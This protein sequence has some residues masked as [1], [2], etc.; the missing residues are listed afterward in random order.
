[1]KVKATLAVFLCAIG[2]PV[3]ARGQNLIT[4]G[5]FETGNFSGWTVSGNPQY[6]LVAGFSYGYFHPESGND[7]AMLGSIGSESFLSQTISTNPGSYYSVSFDLASDG[8]TTNQL[9]VLA[10][11]DTLL[12]VTD[13]PKSNYTV[14]TGDFTA[15]SD[16]TT[17]SIGT[18]DDPGYLLLDNVSVVDPPS[19]APL[20]ST[21]GM[22]ALLMAGF[23]GFQIYRKRSIVA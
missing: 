2:L 10:G 16:A 15:T 12:N 4:N 6:S 23:V 9:T 5:S 13:I 18:R 21:V 19:P 14:Y 1:L 8:G 20:P 17:V 11:S 7:Y 22:A 3:I